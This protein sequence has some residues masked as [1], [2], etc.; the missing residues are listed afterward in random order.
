[1]KPKHLTI[2]STAL[3]MICLGAVVSV[4][5]QNPTTVCDYFSANIGF[6]VNTTCSIISAAFLTGHAR[7][8]ASW[9]AIARFL[10][11]TLIAVALDKHESSTSKKL[12]Y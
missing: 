1:M 6:R 11:D 2:L 8:I 10:I 12:V 3:L 9:R 5:A 4:T 7:P